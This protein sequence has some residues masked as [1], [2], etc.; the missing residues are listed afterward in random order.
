[1]ESGYIIQEQGDYDMGLQYIGVL[2]Y[3]TK[4]YMILMMKIIE[5]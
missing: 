5:R 3:N 4:K 2:M 1:M